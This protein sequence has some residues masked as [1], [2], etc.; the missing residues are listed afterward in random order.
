MK[1]TKSINKNCKSVHF[2]CLQTFGR[3]LRH[4]VIQIN[5][6]SFILCKNCILYFSNSINST[7]LF[8]RLVLV[9]LINHTK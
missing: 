2:K 3:S 4:M 7:L 6:I 8:W 1:T 9:L 5:Y